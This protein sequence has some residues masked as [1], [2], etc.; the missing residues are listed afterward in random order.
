[1]KLSSLIA[2]FTLIMMVKGVW[3]AAGVQPV[4]LSLGAILGAI[5][6]DVLNNVELVEFRNFL[7]FINKMDKN[8]PKIAYKEDED[9]AENGPM[10]DIS[11]E[12][13]DRIDKHNKEAEDSFDENEK[14][15]SKRKQ[16]VYGNKG[17]AREKNYWKRKLDNSLEDV[18][19]AEEERDRIEDYIYKK[20]GV[21]FYEDVSMVQDDM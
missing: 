5:E 16:K 3:W 17:D 9:F 4:I 21:E 19:R 2:L 15:V 12:E 18:K 14:E 11:K 20:W 6:L 1:M 10:D 7:P 13:Q 8:K